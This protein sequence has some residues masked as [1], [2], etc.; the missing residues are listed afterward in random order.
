LA[1]A[2]AA[3]AEAS[4]DLRQARE[5]RDG[6]LLD[7]TPAALKQA[8]AA[9]AA[10]T[11]PAERIA[12]IRRQLEQRLTAAIEAET[13]AGTEAAREALVTAVAAHAKWWLSVRETLAAQLM[14]GLA[15]KNAASDAQHA[16]D[17]MV[18][19]ATDKY[20]H[21]AFEQ[22]APNPDDPG[23]WTADLAIASRLEDFAYLAALPKR[24]E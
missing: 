4:A 11:E 8:E 2:V 10:A 14:A 23:S 1:R 18:R 19:S 7:G 6:L 24:A 22:P 9:L 3:D 15:L 16:W 5:Q 17:R 20:P 21:L 13:V 12:T